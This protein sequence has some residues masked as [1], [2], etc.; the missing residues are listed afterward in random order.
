VNSYLDIYIGKYSILA[1]LARCLTLLPNLHTVQIYAGE[2]FKLER[3]FEA[4]FNKYSYPQIR[5]VFVMFPSIPFIASCPQA[6]RVGLKG[7]WFISSVSN[8]CLQ[9]MTDNC[10]HLEVIDFPELYWTSKD[11]ERTILYCFFLFANS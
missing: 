7:R 4:A 10:P 9:T 2:Q 1:E 8:S 5:N 6:R 3:H 11:C